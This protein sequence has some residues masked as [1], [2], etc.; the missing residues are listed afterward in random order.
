MPELLETV[1]S[2][3]TDNKKTASAITIAAAA[4]GFF[5]QF[6]SYYAHASDIEGLRKS[7]ENAIVQQRIES[8]YSMDQIRRQY[9]EDKIFEINL[10]SHPTQVQKA[11]LEK[12]Q[13]DLN[14]INTK[15]QQQTQSISK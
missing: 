5:L 2:A 6:D 15:W 11:M 4:I 9:L 13:S 10:I 3:V 1:V 8:R 12:Y 7:Q 14:M